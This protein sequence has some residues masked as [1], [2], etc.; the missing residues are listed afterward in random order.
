M[1]VPRTQVVGIAVSKLELSLFAHVQGLTSQEEREGLA[2]QTSIIKPLFDDFNGF[3]VL[4]S[5]S[6]PWISRS[7]W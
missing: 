2:C 4:T 6:D 7:A 5:C 3:V 1:R